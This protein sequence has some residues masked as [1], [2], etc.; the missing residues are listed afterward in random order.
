VHGAD[1]RA[2]PD[3]RYKAIAAPRDIDNESTPIASVAQRAAQCR[4]MDSEVGRLDK[5]VGPNPSYQL[6]LTD[7]LAR[8]FKQDNEH[9][10]G[11]TADRH[12][13]VSFQ[14]K[15]LC[16]QQAKSPNEISRAIAPAGL[17]AF[18]WLA[19]GLC[20]GRRTSKLESELYRSNT[21]VSAIGIVS[22]R[23]ESVMLYER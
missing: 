20:R 13:F 9:L 15:K 7:Q 6:L 14:Q 22:R 3:W 5:Q 8:P 18:A 12:R 16:R 17:P 2:L 1:K 23:R 19:S 11:A 4:N 21:G 10:H